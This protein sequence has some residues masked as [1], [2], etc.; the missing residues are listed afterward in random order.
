MPTLSSLRRLLPYYRPYR[1]DVAWGWPW[2]SRRQR[3]RAWFRGFCAARS[4]EFAPASAVSYIWLLGATMIGVTVARRRR[5][6]WMRELLNGVSRWIEYDLRNDLFLA[7]ENADP[8]YY[9]RMR[10][11]DLMARLTNDLSAVRMAAGPAIMYLANTIFGGAFALG[12]HAAHLAAAHGRRRAADGAAADPRHRARAGAFT[13][14]SRRC[15]RTSAISRRS[16]RRISPAC[17]SCA[18]FGRKTPRSRGSRR[19]TRTISRRTCGS[20]KLYGD[21]A[22]GLRDLRRLRHGRRGRRSAARS[23]CAARSPSALRRVRHVPRHAD[24]AADRARLGDQ[25]VPARRGV[26]DAP[27]RHPRRD[28]RCSSKPPVPASLP[29]ASGAGRTIEFR[30]V[31]FH[32]PRPNAARRRAAL[33]AAQRQSSRRRRGRRS[34]SSARRR[35]ARAR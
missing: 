22:A 16:R 2:S 34:A 26:D 7:L 25:S 21:H 6:Y 4:T 33:G 10:T 13:R 3:S 15:R 28:S 9:A 8:T 1:R 31:G 19:S 11:G 14:A 23:S 12:V 5:R 24:V 20:R 30:D 17:A 35:A 32:Y 18:R 29:P 27:A